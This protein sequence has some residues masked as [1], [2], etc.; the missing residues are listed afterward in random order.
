M[1]QQQR[2]LVALQTEMR[3]SIADVMQMT[4]GALAY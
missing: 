1:Q 2:Q 4:F 3:E